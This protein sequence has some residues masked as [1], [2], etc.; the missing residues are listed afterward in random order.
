VLRENGKLRL[1]FASTDF[2]GGTGVHTLHESTSDDGIQWSAPSP[3]QLEGIYAP[4]ILKEDGTYRMWYSDVSA[5][6]WIV[7]HAHSTDGKTWERTETPCIVI[8]QDWERSRLFYPAVLKH[9][10]QYVLWYGAYWSAR[11]NTTAIGS[12]VSD[13]GLTWRKAPNNPVFTPDESRPWESHYTTSQ[14][15]LKLDDGTWR[16]WYASRKAPPFLN[17][18]FA[19]GTARWEG[20]GAAESQASPWPARATD[21]RLRMARALTLPESRVPLDAQTHR[22]TPGDGYRIESVT[23]ASE[24]GSRVTALLYLPESVGPLPAVVVACG[25][26][27]SKSAL[28]AQYAGQLYAKFGFACLV[29]DTIGEEERHN[30]RKMGARGHDLYHLPK[31]ERGPF[32]VNEMRRSILGKIVW[33]LMR[34][35]DYLETR[36][37]VDSTRVGVVGYSLGGASASTLAILDPRV[38]CAVIA[39][40]G[41]IPS[42]AVYGKPCTLVPYQDFAGMMDFSEL[43]A[44]LAPHAATLFLSGAVDTI[45]DPTGGGAVFKGEIESSVHEAKVLLGGAGIPCELEAE[46]VESGCHRPYFLT[47]RA[48]QWMQQHLQG[49]VS[50]TQ[51]ATINYGTWVDSQGQQIEELY[52]TE[53]RERGTT[54]V[55]VS[56][57]YRDPAS[58]ACLPPDAPPPGEYTFEGWMNQCLAQAGVGGLKTQ[59][60]QSDLTDQSDPSDQS[61]P[62]TCEAGSGSGSTPASLD[63]RI[64]ATVRAYADTMLRAGRDHYGPQQTPLF[65]AALDRD[66]LALLDGDRLEQ[67]KNIPREEWGIRNH[68]RALTGANPMHDQNLYQV[69]YALTA[70]TGE[71]GYASAADEALRWFFTHACSPETGLLAWGEHLSWDF[72]EE[73]PFLAAGGD[74]GNHEYYRP[75]VLWERTCNLAPEGA[76]RFAAAVW[77]HQIGDHQTGA[78][79]RHA[80]FAAHRTATDSEYPRHGGFYIATWAYAYQATG[81]EAFLR[82]I[83]TL[84]KYFEGRRNPVSGA[85]PA[86]SAERSK[87]MTIWP[88]SNLSLAIDLSDGATRVTEPTATMMRA[89][90]EKTD[91]I[92]LSVAHELSEAGKGFATIAHAETLACTSFTR[93][94]ATGYGEA[95]DAQVANLGLLRYAQR[96]LEGYRTLALA[97]AERYLNSAPDTSIPLYPGALADAIELMINCHAASDAPRYL[98]RAEYFA[99]EALRIFF[100]SGPLPRASAKHDHYEAITRGD[101]LAMELLRLWAIKNRP[102]VA[103]Q[104]VWNER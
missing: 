17:K 5:D 103:A 40:W 13:D 100:D 85:L 27:G 76:A 59:T 8:D 6:P 84:V 39:G 28:Y 19:I 61:A 34:G 82:Y 47:P 50:D 20:P 31:E 91:A 26:G 78:F 2:A 42:L 104:L 35:I 57:V 62:T 80:G 96:P 7:R 46:F 21:L 102:E 92:Y 66:T 36:P 11:D 15:V 68:D 29:V 48:L 52:A 51:P 3:A 89:C 73:K 41:T 30:D 16:M 33:D 81:D 32:M 99:E 69:L 25:H 67:I 79:S 1:W 60:D 18:Y 12:A 101:T 87:G 97:A 56:A 83:E 72:R 23:Y 22:T 37:E 93:P 10:G 94:W 70:I 9:E 55:D 58:L 43:T 77:E 38:K 75:W 95:T 14:S 65:A 71:P 63:E 74:V 24:P 49:G 54:V 64:L 90:A 44:L 45:M 53:A 98:A 88:P 86:E 4:T